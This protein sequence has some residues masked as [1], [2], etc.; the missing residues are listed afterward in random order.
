MF[1]GEYNHTLDAKKRLALPSKFRKVLGGKVVITKGLEGCLSVYTEKEW[2]TMSEK[3]GKLPISH[4][5]ARGFARMMLA[6]AMLVNIDSL[7]RILIPDYLKD[8]AGLKKNIMI[9]GLLNRLE[10]WDENK[11]NGYKNNAEKKFEDF[12]SKLGDLGI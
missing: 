6:G 1:I 7:G 10:L 2:R 8:Y 12:A 3:L 5:E 11:W 4:A 9:C